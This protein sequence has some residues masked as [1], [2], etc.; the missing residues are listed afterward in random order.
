MPNNI[1]WR[2]CVAAARADEPKSNADGREDQTL[3][4][5]ESQNLRTLRP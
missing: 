3:A 1:P 4:K 2:Y 5:H